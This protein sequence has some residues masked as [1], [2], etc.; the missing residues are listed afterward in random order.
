MSFRLG[1]AQIKNQHFRQIFWCRGGNSNETLCIC[2][3]LKSWYKHEARIAREMRL[4]NW[5][6][7]SIR[8]PPSLL[9]HSSIMLEWFKFA[10]SHTAG[11]DTGKK[12]NE[13]NKKVC[14]SICFLT[15]LTLVWVAAATDGE[16]TTPFR[17]H[18][19][20]FSMFNW[21]WNHENMR[22]QLL[23]TYECY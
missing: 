18:T 2:G 17:A 5:P 9:L 20:R 10:L 7:F 4:G 11:K 16:G 3:L 21:V 15:K 12:M 14:S 1:L 22:L 6:R 19:K 8:R 23:P 13:R